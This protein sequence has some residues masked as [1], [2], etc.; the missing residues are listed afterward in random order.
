MSALLFVASACILGWLG[1]KL[2][3]A[4]KI[5]QVFNVSEAITMMAVNTVAWM[6]AMLG[7][8]LL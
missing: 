4:A 5:Q 8:A 6:L 1:E 3:Y 2:V 7:V